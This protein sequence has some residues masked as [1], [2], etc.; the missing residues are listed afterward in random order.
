MDRLIIFKNNFKKAIEGH[1][2]ASKKYQGLLDEI[3]VTIFDKD[4]RNG[5]FFQVA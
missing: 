4:D 2:V 3:N 1:K 5:T